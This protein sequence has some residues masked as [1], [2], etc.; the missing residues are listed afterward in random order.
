[1]AQVQH[2]GEL[3]LTQSGHLVLTVPSAFI[4]GQF[5]T[6]DAPGI[7]LPMTESSRLASHIIVMTPAELANKG[8]ITERGKQFSYRLGDISEQTGDYRN[9]TTPAWR[10]ASKLYVMPVHSP[11][12]Q[13]L[14]KTYGLEPRDLKL[15]VAMV[16][17]NVLRRG[18]AMKYAMAGT[19]AYLLNH[20]K[21]AM[22]SRL[23]QQYRDA[24]AS[25]ETPKSKAQAEAGN[26]K[27]GHVRA[28]GLQFSIETAKGKKRGPDWPELTANYGYI[29]QVYDPKQQKYVTV[30]EDADGDH[31][32]C[33]LNDELDSMNVYVIDQL[34]SGTRE[35]D[36]HKVMIG[37]DTAKDAKAAYKASF[38]DDWKGMGNVTKLT[39]PQFKQW[40]IAGDKKS[41]IAGQAFSVKEGKDA[42][43]D[44]EAPVAM[45][46][47][48]SCTIR[49]L[50]PELDDDEAK[51]LMDGILSKKDKK[52]DPPE[53]PD[54]I[55]ELFEGLP[56][57]LREV[58]TCC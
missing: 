21:Q 10:N 14:R 2:T 23:R 25:V 27:H 40:L 46:I 6:L 53:L 7:E 37:F 39:M 42:D 48:R 58:L 29:T 28:Y 52:G 5:A 4:R 26:Y 41:P 33:F 34:K 8:N 12:L 50:G 54:D 47:H 38:T 19:L 36:E 45:I 20:T 35:F 51:D 32:D 44:D 11:E 16:K 31:V 1:M 43:E 18:P 3:Q 17:R 9:N 22:P 30:G 49:V 24:V 55:S 15:V 13:R 57:S 56:D